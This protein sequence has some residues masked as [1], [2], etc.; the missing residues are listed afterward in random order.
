MDTTSD[1]YNDAEIETIKKI[2]Q[3]LT[4]D[5]IGKISYKNRNVTVKVTCKVECDSLSG[6]VKFGSL[7]DVIEIKQEQNKNI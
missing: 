7:I 4:N 2:S 6:E 3:Q 5:L 1:F